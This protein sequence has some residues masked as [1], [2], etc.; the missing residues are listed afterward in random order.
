MI[1]GGRTVEAT[2]RLSRETQPT[3]WAVGTP[4]VTA[5]SS[6]HAMPLSPA[7]PARRDGTVDLRRV[8]R[9]AAQTRNPRSHFGNY[10]LAGD[11]LAGTA[12]MDDGLT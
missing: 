11:G 4:L 5:E 10:C 6:K 1:R 8:A 3:H 9:R 12:V 7:R 2:M